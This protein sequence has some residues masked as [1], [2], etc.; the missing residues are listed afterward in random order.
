[1]AKCSIT[2]ITLQDTVNVSHNRAR[3][4]SSPENMAINHWHLINTFKVSS[5]VKLTV[6]R[7]L[8]RGVT[9]PTDPRG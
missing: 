6:L 8:G 9:P 5:S 7:H 3:F 1:M 4:Y 2:V